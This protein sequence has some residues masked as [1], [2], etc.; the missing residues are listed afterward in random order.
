MIEGMAGGKETARRGHGARWATASESS[1]PPARTSRLWLDARA[2]SVTEG[3]RVA[4]V[5]EK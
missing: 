2:H 4:P 3:D 5:G 1:G